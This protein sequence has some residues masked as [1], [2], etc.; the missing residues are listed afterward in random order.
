[1]LPSS[2]DLVAVAVNIWF[3]VGELGDSDTVAVGA[4]LLSVSRKFCVGLMVLP[5]E[6]V[7]VSDVYPGAD[8]INVSVPVDPEKLNERSSR[9]RRWTSSTGPSCCI[10]PC[11]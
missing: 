9:R 6:T 10:E 5:T 4:V 7:L 8:A 2:S 3:V 11:R 1:M